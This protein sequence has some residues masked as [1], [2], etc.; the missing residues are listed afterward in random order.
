[1]SSILADQQR[2]RII[3]MSPNAGGGV[4]CGV[5]ANEYSCAYGALINFGDLTPY[6]TYCSK[7]GPVLIQLE[8]GL[9]HL[10]VKISKCFKT[11]K[12]N[13]TVYSAREKLNKIEDFYFSHSEHF[14][15]MLEGQKKRKNNYCHLRITDCNVSVSALIFRLTIY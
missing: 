5:S 14:L 4:R 7:S 12:L 6:V 3:N 9:V 2:P 13:F 10:K 11:K 15:K 8:K 1:M